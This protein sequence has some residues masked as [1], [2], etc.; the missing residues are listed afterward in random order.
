[1]A[2]QTSRLGDIFAAI[3]DKINSIMPKLVPPA[4]TTGQVL[5]KASN[6]DH[7]LGWVTP[8]SGAAWGGITGT[9]ANQTDLKTALDAKATTAALN[10]LS[11]SNGQAVDSLTENLANKAPSASP[12][13]TGIPKAPTAP[14]GTNTTQIASTGFVAAAIAAAP[15]PSSRVITYT[16]TTT[17]TLNAATTDFIDITAQAAS[18]NSSSGSSGTPTN[19]QKLMI[20]ICDNGTSRQITALASF[21]TK[22]GVSVPTAT[23]AGKVMLLGYIYNSPKGRWE[24]VSVAQE[25]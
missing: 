19:G 18:L 13:L 16:S 7:S 6:A 1:M 14:A 24:C 15:P 11:I 20:R 2:T 8:V 21:G 17:F 10:S 25:T 5:S 22:I 9:L 23:V 12:N 3:R 4:G